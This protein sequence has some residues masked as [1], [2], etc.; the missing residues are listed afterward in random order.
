MTS[1]G[2]SFDIVVVGGGINGAGIARDAAGRGLRVLLVEQ[3]DFAGATSSASTK[4]IHGGLR[5]L[6]HREWRLVAESL[7]E[8]EVLLRLASHIAW[9]MRFVMP[10][11]PHLRPAWMIRTGLWLYDRLGGR[12][13]LPK[14]QAVRLRGTPWGEGLAADLERG[15]VYSDAW[16][17]DARLVVLNLRSATAHGAQVLRDTRLV[18]AQARQGTWT[19]HLAP[20][21]SDSQA[22]QWTVQARAVV[23]ATGAWVGAVRSACVGR[24]M[25]QARLVRG[26]HIVVPRVHAGA[27]ACLFQNA[28][29]RV[30]FAIPYEGRYTLVG[31][32]D[33]P[34]DSVAEAHT[35]GD[36][37][38]DYLLAAVNRFLARPLSRADVVW[39][40]SGVRALVDD[41]AD[42]PSAV[43]RDYRLELDLQDGAPL[44]SVYGG[45]LTTYR[46]LAEAALQRLAGPMGL[47]AGPWTATEPL[48]GAPGAPGAPGTPP[49]PGDRESALQTLL[50]RHPALPQPLLEGLFA[51]H[52]T[53]VDELLAGAQDEAGLG[54]HHGGGLWDCEVRWCRTHEWARQPEDV[55]WRRTKAGL[56][57]SAAEREAFAR[58]WEAMA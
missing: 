3:G 45:K 49:A 25:P 34:V 28:D 58:A 52:G 35:V 47:S 41:G 36:D 22:E 23:N 24:P 15:Y 1:D 10:H 55:L 11:L 50:H 16:V 51:R 42:K 40:Y 44:L 32:T 56:H 31:T 57:M 27:H 53:L 12:S 8:R 29:G 54:H 4:L 14:S 13:S 21:D 30:L 19:V 7:A 48:P 6:E 33:R 38:V 39:S 2:Q 46:R 5:Y 43:T 26:S 9:P 20:T 37:E 17:D 18:S